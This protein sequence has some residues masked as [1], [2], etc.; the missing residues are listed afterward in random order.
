M[1][2]D[3]RNDF[4]ITTDP[5]SVG[6]LEIKKRTDR[7]SMLRKLFNQTTILRAPNTNL[8]IGRSTENIKII[9]H[10]KFGETNDRPSVLFGGGRDITVRVGVC[11]GSDFPNVDS[12]A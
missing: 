8:R 6:L 7:A 3:F 1:K 5:K 4:V 12:F 10:C 2:I 9:L 11:V